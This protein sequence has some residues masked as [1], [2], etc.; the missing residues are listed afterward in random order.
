MVL[1]SEEK[2]VDKDNVIGS[3]IRKIHKDKEVGQTG[4]LKRLQMI[5]I[6][7]NRKWSSVYQARLITKRK[8]IF[9]KLIMKYCLMTTS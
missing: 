2:I 5:N 1:M 3:N 7:E 9:Y 6:S 4:L 8:I